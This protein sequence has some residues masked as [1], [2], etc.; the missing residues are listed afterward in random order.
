MF[1]PSNARSPS[2]GKA[3]AKP[4]AGLQASSR[5]S[6]IAGLSGAAD[7]WRDALLI[8]RAGSKAFFFSK[9]QSCAIAAFEL[10]CN[11]MGEA[12]KFMARFCNA[13][14]SRSASPG[15]V[16]VQTVEFGFNW[17]AI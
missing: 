2:S 6:N 11:F 14:K 10:L 12:A 5:R 4:V 13:K 17:R 16:V 3:Q 7:P 1:H 15:Q 9:S 8:D